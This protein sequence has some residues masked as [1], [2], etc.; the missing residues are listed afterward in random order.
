MTLARAAAPGRVR[1]GRIFVTPRERFTVR[2]EYRHALWFPL[3]RE[4]GGVHVGVG[5]DPNHTL[6][7][8]ARSECVCPLDIDLA[9]YLQRVRP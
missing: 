4:L 7:A 8:A 5:S 6:L 3:M 2:D 1:S 9:V